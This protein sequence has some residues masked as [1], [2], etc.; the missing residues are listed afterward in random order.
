VSR[1]HTCLLVLVLWCLGGA[2]AE[3]EARSVSKKRREDGVGR[4]RP[5]CV[6]RHPARRRQIP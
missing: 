2:E 6:N 3:A 4:R 1:R 5:A